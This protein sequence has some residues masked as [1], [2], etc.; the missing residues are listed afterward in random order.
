MLLTCCTV[1][2]DFSLSK[3]FDFRLS[4]RVFRGTGRYPLLII[5]SLPAVRAGASFRGILRM[6]SCE[7][8]R[9]N[10]VLLTNGLRCFRSSGRTVVRGVCSSSYVVSLS[11]NKT[12][13]RR[14][15]VGQVSFAQPVA[16]RKKGRR[17][18]SS[19]FLLRGRVRT[20]FSHQSVDNF[21][22]GAYGLRSLYGSRRKCPLLANFYGVSATFIFFDSVRIALLRT[23]VIRGLASFLGGLCLRRPS[24]AM[25]FRFPL[26]G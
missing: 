5:G 20:F 4:R 21:L 26:G 10:G 11:L 22:R 19:Y 23:P 12:A 17:V 7:I 13:K 2:S 1:P 6:L 25:C 3:H 8:R 24:T 15:R 14:H 9:R 18:A 16:V